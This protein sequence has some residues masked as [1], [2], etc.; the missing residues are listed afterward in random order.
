VI[1][2]EKLGRLLIF[3]ATDAYTP[4]GDLPDY[5]QGSYALIIA[6]DKG[7][8]A[9]MP[10]TPPDTDLLERNI[11]VS[12][13]EFGEIRGTIRER[14][15]GQASVAFRREFRSVAA[16]DFRKM[17]E[18][19]L[20][21]GAT[22]ARLEELQTKDGENR[23]TFNLDVS[24]SAL[25]YGQLMQNRLLV[26]KPVIVGR[27]HGVSLTE[28]TRTSP[29]EING[30]SMK[31]TVSFTLPDGFSVD[32]MPDAASLQTVF[33]SYSTK[34]E[35]SGNNLKFS[36]VLKLNRMTLPAEKYAVA[37]E[38]FSKMREAEQAPVV[39]IRK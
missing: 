20:T 28:P 5:L 14:S 15:T 31:E 34:Y 4:V 35:V 18:G 17:I 30:L 22:G 11:D 6:G 36:R 7:G 1:E 29:I 24:F 23:S 26:F 27:R 25:R 37:K 32:E 2:N 19:W 38:F 33:G 10:I 13:N 8:L 3:D 12:L 21:N 39:L 9:K 16:P